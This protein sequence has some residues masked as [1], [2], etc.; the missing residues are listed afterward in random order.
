[1]TSTKKTRKCDKRLHW[2]R[3]GHFLKA[4]GV[5][6]KRLDFFTSSQRRVNNDLRQELQEL[7][8]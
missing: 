3:G 8:A 5:G 7:K 6:I 2:G 4:K 1:M